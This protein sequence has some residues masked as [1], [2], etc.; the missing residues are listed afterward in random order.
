[1]SCDRNMVWFEK[2][3]KPTQ[4]PKARQTDP[5]TIR[6]ALA[7][8]S[9]GQATSLP[10]TLFS[11]TVATFALKAKPK[12]VSCYVCCFPIGTTLD[13]RLVLSSGLIP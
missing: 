7:W 6:E 12:L 8:L 11:L 2:L 5:A 4:F 10:L 9:T 13:L 3:P 1:M